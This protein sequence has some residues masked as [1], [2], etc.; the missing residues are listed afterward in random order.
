MMRRKFSSVEEAQAD[1]RKL[2]APNRFIYE[3]VEVVE[4]TVKT[5]PTS[6]VVDLPAVP[7]VKL[8]KE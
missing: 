3:V 1:A 6:V 7:P 2:N 5:I 8:V 4:A